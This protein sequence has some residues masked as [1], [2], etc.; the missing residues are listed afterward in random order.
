MDNIQGYWEI[1]EYPESTFS[2]SLNIEKTSMSL[3]CY[4]N[5][6]PSMVLTMR[7]Y[8]EY[9]AGKN[10]TKGP[11]TVFGAVMRHN[12]SNLIPAIASFEFDIQEVILG[13]LVSGKDSNVFKK[14]TFK[15]SDLENWLNLRLKFTSNFDKEKDEY[16]ME[17]KAKSKKLEYL[18]DGK[19]I[20]INQ[21]SS[22]PIGRS[23]DTTL[24]VDAN[25]TFEYDKLTNLTEIIKDLDTFRKFYSFINNLP[26]YPSYVSL[27]S[28]SEK[29]DIQNR[30]E[31]YNKRYLQEDKTRRIQEK[32]LKFSD[33]KDN[34]TDLYNSW[35]KFYVLRSNFCDGFLKDY[36][37][38]PTDYQSIFINLASIFDNYL[39]KT[40]GT[41]GKNNYFRT[42]LNKFYKDNEE[43]AEGFIYSYHIKGDYSMESFTNDFK[44]KRDE[45]AHGETVP[46]DEA[47]V[48]LIVRLRFICSYIILTNLTFTKE[49]AVNIL[50]DFRKKNHGYSF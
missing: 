16:S 33:I 6:K 15:I 50:T 20:V 30:F 10:S 48:E 37:T 42:R 17:Y 2:G 21:W 8:Y 3:N 39:Q 34:F 12:T 26:S 36:F 47:L 41:K 40:Y 4:T 22:M 45:L 24:R 13:A 7:N 19:K 14:V 32:L 27:R 29:P 38:T 28:D 43:L 18:L 23:V 9:I 1:K 44:S 35:V 46:V 5:L 11:V 31:Y 49:Q 25:I